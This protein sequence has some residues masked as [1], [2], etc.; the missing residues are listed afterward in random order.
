MNSECL[1]FVKTTVIIEGL[2]TVDDC[3]RVTELCNMC[4]KEPQVCI[5]LLVLVRQRRHVVCPSVLLSPFS[6]FSCLNTV[7]TKTLPRVTFKTRRSIRTFTN[8]L[9][10]TLL[11][12]LY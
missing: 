4:R 10:L 8:L 6:H 11:L 7:E 9:R 1:H 3:Q 5:S 2:G 12:D